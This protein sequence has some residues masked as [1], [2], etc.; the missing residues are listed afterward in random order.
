MFICS[1]VK[2]IASESQNMNLRKQSFPINQ[3]YSQ[4][5][6]ITPSCIITHTFLYFFASATELTAIFI[7]S[8]IIQKVLNGF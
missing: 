3:K 7:V 2:T 8:K 4:I 5:I 1:S 6:S